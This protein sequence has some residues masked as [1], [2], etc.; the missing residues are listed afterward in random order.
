MSIGFLIYYESWDVLRVLK[1]GFRTV[2]D[3]TGEKGDFFNCDTKVI[4]KDYIHVDHIT[5]KKDSIIW[6]ITFLH[7]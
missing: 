4:K 7:Y 1:N 2:R 3:P 6:P 5:H